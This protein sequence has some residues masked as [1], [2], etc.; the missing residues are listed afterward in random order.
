MTT[1]SDLA[2]EGVD[3][4]LTGH[5]LRSY[6]IEQRQLLT[7]FLPSAMELSGALRS[8]DRCPHGNSWGNCSY[9][10]CQ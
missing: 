3:K 8:N 5:A 4:G 9:A 6:V 10:G 2:R 7:G 1:T